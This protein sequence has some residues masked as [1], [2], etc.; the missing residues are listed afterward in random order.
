MHSNLTPLLISVTGEY[1]EGVSDQDV[2]LIHSCRQWTTVTA[3]SLE[4]GHYVIGP[5]IDIPLQYPGNRM[6]RIQWSTYLKGSSE[7]GLDSKRI[8]ISTDTLIVVLTSWMSLLRLL[9]FLSFFYF[10]SVVMY[11]FWNL[12][13][14]I[15]L[16][17]VIND[18]VKKID[19]CLTNL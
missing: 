17:W 14:S 11:F 7:W 12:D 4:E 18:K 15:T 8:D 6:V 10:W 5:K 16:S 9:S 13:A 1:V 3:H 19:P 2:L